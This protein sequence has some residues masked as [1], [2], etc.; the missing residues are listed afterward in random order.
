MW[1][2]ILHRAT[3]VAVLLF[4]LVHIIDTMLIG[5]GP[6]LYNQAINLYR[7]PFFRVGEVFLAAAVLYHAINGVRIM[8]VDFWPG[9]TRLH[10][11]LFYAGVI[12]FLVVF[13][14]SAYF[15]LRP[16]FF[17]GA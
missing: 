10:R 3:G 1:S 16:V 7:N 8:I 17:P 14:P 2:W 5:F 15:M 4:L 9:S 13:I 6:S 12:L 11:K